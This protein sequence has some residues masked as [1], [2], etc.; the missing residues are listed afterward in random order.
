MNNPH[1]VSLTYAL[2]PGDE[3]SYRNPPRLE[4]ENAL[5]TGVLDE[6]TLTLRPK[7]H[8]PSIFAAR[9]LADRFLRAWELDATLN[10][11]RG[12]IA[13]EYRTGEV[14]DRD[15]PP[16]GSPQS[17]E[18]Q[19]ASHALIGCQASVHVTRSKYPDPPEYFQ[20][21]PDVEVLWGRIEGYRLG[22][23]PLLSMAYFC[24]SWLERRMAN[25]REDAA[26]VLNAEK[27]VLGKLGELTSKRGD[28]SMARK[29]SHSPQPLSDAERVWIIA[30]LEKLLRNAG[31]LGKRLP[32]R[33]TLKDLPEL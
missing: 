6:G 20:F 2:K 14:I 16:P 32:P 23:E 24:L 13:F 7:D 19:C 22:R 5:F 21:T 12:S 10:G 26:L 25:S 17:I 3:V 28:S 15:P 1:V 33:I 30:A 29:A 4:F 18:V 9:E 27:P 31:E 11:G 8:Y